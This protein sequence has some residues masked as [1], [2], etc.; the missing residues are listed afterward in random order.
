MKGNQLTAKYE[1]GT[2]R[3]TYQL[4]PSITPNNPSFIQYIKSILN[5]RLLGK[6][7]TI[8]DI[9]L[10]LVLSFAL[11]LMMC[12]VYQ[13]TH[14]NAFYRQTYAQAMIIISMVVSVIMI[15]VGSNIIR[16]FSLIGAMSIVRF[17][18]AV[19]DTRDISY[20]FFAIALGMACGTGF[21]L[22]AMIATIVISLCA[23]LMH[24]MNFFAKDVCKKILKIRLSS[25]IPYDAVFSE[26]FD[27]Y[28]R[29]FELITVETVQAGL[30]TELVYMTE[31]KNQSNIQ[32]FMEALRMLNNNNKVVLMNEYYR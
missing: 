31:L 32:E 2:Y 14:Q 4:I 20:I 22:V 24:Q 28:L 16:A 6:H 18:N 13:K 7:H 19:R 8:K 30:L 29:H 17:R 11:S 15:V 1:S 5:R 3:N 23:L 26:V 25:D 10:A 27:K 9:P 12:K 21:Y